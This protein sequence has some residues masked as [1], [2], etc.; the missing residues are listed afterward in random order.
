MNSILTLNAI[1]FE[2][3]TPQRI[4]LASAS[5]KG[6]RQAALPKDL[7]EFY[8][9]T[10]GFIYKE[11]QIFGIN[12][13]KRDAKFYT[14]PNIMDYNKVFTVIDKNNM[15]IFGIY[16]S[17]FLVYFEKDKNF[18]VVDKTSLIIKKEYKS[19]VDMMRGELDI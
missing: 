11:F 4:E 17:A 7:I 10:D 16:K 14:F 18:S 15:V 12:D 3:S 2:S 5:L 9:M 8:S 13:H 19:L 1:F 6:N